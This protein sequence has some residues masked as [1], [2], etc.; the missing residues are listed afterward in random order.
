M[1]VCDPIIGC[2]S[3]LM[4]VYVISG[5]KSTGPGVDTFEER[6]EKYLSGE[7]EDPP[8]EH[9]VFLE[10]LCMVVQEQLAGSSD[11]QVVAISLIL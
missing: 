8:G 6:M 11:D 5:V 3:V 4:T 2:P 7:L 1:L 9:T 10:C